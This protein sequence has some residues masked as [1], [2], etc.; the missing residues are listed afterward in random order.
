MKAAHKKKLQI[1]K[2]KT[3]QVKAHIK[4]LKQRKKNKKP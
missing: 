2:K 1:L 3:L 4:A